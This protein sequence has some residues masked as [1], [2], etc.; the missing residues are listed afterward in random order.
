MRIDGHGYSA[1]I[2]GRILHV[3]SAI[4]SFEDGATALEV[5]GEIEISSRQ[6]NKLCSEYGQEMADDRD[7]RTQQYVEQDL[8]RKA[9]QPEV[10]ID[11]AAVFF[12]G[13]RMRTR[14]PERGPGVHDPHWRE[15]KNAA[16]H[17]MRSDSFEDDPQPDLP[18]CFRNQAYVE[19]LVKGLKKSKKEGREEEVTPEAGET[20]SVEERVVEVPEWQPETLF[21]TVISSLSASEEFG[22]MMAAEADARGFFAAQKKAFL[23]DGLTCNWRIHAR[24]FPDFVATVD[25]VHVVEHIYEVAKAVH[26]DITTRWQQY[27]AWATACWQGRVEDFLE[28]MRA[29]QEALGGPPDETVMD[30]DPR[31]VLREAITYF[32]NNRTRMDYPSYRRQGLPITSSLAESLVKQINKRVKGTEKFWNDGS[33]GEAIL[34]VRAAG[35]CDDDRLQ[36]WVQNRPISPFSPRCSTA[37]PCLAA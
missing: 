8:P 19:K 31:N 9:T 25:F 17:R 18:D 2:L 36:R 20:T 35:L 33:P 24:W 30:T 32:T 1:T 12:D 5:V 4:S 16:F 14:Q 6:L 21:R 34:Q 37:P 26:A 23:G 27:V 22:P 29:W 13:G 15:T 7:A 3:I 28:Q 11:L 10:P